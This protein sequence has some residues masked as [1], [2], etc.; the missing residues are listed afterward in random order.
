[1]AGERILQS[2]R[3]LTNPA[4]DAPATSDEQNP[5]QTR[6]SRGRQQPRADRPETQGRGICSAN[7]PFNSLQ[8]PLRWCST[9]FVHKEASSSTME[10]FLPF[11][12]EETQSIRP[13]SAEPAHVESW[14]PSV[15]TPKKSCL[16]RS[17]SRTSYHRWRDLRDHCYSCQ[18]AAKFAQFGSVG[19]HPC[20]AVPHGTHRL[21]RAFGCACFPMD[22][23]SRDRCP[24]WCAHG[25]GRFPLRS[26]LDLDQDF[27]IRYP[28]PSDALACNCRACSAIHHTIRDRLR[29][30]PAPGGPDRSHGRPDWKGTCAASTARLG[31]AGL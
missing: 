23:K 24:R 2:P 1:M 16:Y 26:D 21:E 20:S 22:G 25:T 17:E 4:Q 28:T 30:V 6:P 13:F 11:T 14:H 7:K 12:G 10:A 8:N 9:I 31:G 27:R 18:S 15:C 5:V 3:Q 29:G 19:E